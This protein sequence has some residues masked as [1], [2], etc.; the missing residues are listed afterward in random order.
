[1]DPA[2]VNRANDSNF[3]SF[4]NNSNRLS[5][6]D[7]SNLPSVH[8]DSTRF[9]PFHMKTYHQDYPPALVQPET[10]LLFLLSGSALVI[11]D[12]NSFPVQAEDIFLIN[13]NETVQIA[14]ASWDAIGLSF[15]SDEIARSMGTRPDRF[16]VC[17]SG[18]TYSARYD[19]LRF[20]MAHLADFNPRKEAVFRSLSIFYA[21]YS[22]LTANHKAPPLQT[23]SP[24]RQNREKLQ[25][26][27]QFINEH[28]KENL[29]LSDAAS[30]LNYSN[31][32]F[33]AFFKKYAG[34]TFL[35]YYNEIRLNH[36][37]RDLLSG[38]DSIE[39]IALKNG[40]SD[41]RSLTTLFKR[42]YQ[43]LPNLYRRS[44]SL[45]AVQDGSAITG[46]AVYAET[47]DGFSV[48][49]G[50]EFSS[51]AENGVSARAERAA[52][53]PKT[54]SGQHP[55][56]AKYLNVFREDHDFNS[57][58]AE[59]PRIIDAGTV[60]FAESI[61]HLTHNYHNMIC[62]GSAKQFL[63]K[64]VQEML[65]R[66]QK[67]IG[68]RYTKFH[69]LLSDDMMVYSE[70]SQGNPHYSFTFIDKVFDF[71]LSIGLRPLCQ[72][73]FM[74]IA[75]AEDPG[76]LVD[77]YHYN[78]SPPK[79]LKKWTDLV[80]ALLEHLIHR[81]GLEEVK[82]WL[83]CVW[84]E[85]DETVSQFSWSNRMR[86]YDFYRSTY[87]AVKSV[88]RELRFGTPSFLLS[89]HEES[90]W[91]N[92]FFSYTV[93]N[94][95]RPDFMNIHYY[96][97]S[98]FE[99]DMRDRFRGERGFSVENMEQS[100]PL[101]VDPYAFMKF[102]NTI[103]GLMRKY[104]MR[105]L[106]IYL[107]EW[108]LTISHRDLINDT[109]FK[110][111]HL[112]KNLLENYDRLESF[113]YWCLTDFIEELQISN[114]LYH[115]GLGLFTYNGIPKAHYNA[116]RLLGYLGDE[117]LKKGDGYFITRSRDRVSILL[118]NYE[119]YSRLFAA[120]SRS[121]LTDTN[122][123]APFEEMSTAR[124][125]VRISGLGTYTRALIKERYVNQSAG[126][127]Y[128]AWARMGNKPDFT[129]EDYAILKQQ[130][131]PGISLHQ[132]TVTDGSLTLH[133]RM[134]PL[135]IRLLEVELS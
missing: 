28:Y 92:G 10:Q 97:N 103:K 108:N 129:R 91:A 113:S 119:H 104:N 50:T 35:D 125:T 31:P 76:R 58:S 111:C 99:H 12:G 114:E 32:Y 89:V 87:R 53:C 74:P 13:G 19:Y 110:S 69:G 68:F 7:D 134:L 66:V 123:Y 33:S 102:I 130:S 78:T 135:E 86:F 2:S 126:S 96:D 90:D 101:T 112:I 57:A 22:H 79:N 75:L 98:L 17:S 24:D 109:C 40:F 67:E 54:S 95:C 56:L 1:M 82:T 127:S 11:A 25:T 118:Y 43:T 121:G 133:T 55:S 59:N 6:P 85:P 84:N 47:G 49:S 122:R 60:P 3:P 18:N 26:V 80:T 77:F 124:F 128:D 27:I 38:R 29:T 83:F 15:D 100:F 63:Y 36:A 81:Y 106:P 64:E 4:H 115:G 71:M 20:C 62:V 42:K 14:G 132:E 73:S 23:A 30:V 61:Q 117:L 41:T 46:G 16:D 39:S 65:I 105:S 45:I 93:L 37:V 9:L 52:D 107:T 34:K 116:F 44:H 21:L 120:G 94:D 70:D 131:L 51:T 72:L 88:C 48:K 8:N 5:V